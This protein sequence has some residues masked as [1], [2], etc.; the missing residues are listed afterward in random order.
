MAKN[1]EGSVSFSTNA[2]L[3]VAL[4][5]TLPNQTCNLRVTKWRL[6]IHLSISFKRIHKWLITALMAT[7]DKGYFVNKP[8][9][10]SEN[11]TSS[12]SIQFP[13][14]SRAIL[15]QEMVKLNWYFLLM[16]FI[17]KRGNGLCEYSVIL[18][19]VASKHEG[20]HIQV[21]KNSYKLCIL[22]INLQFGNSVILKEL[23]KVMS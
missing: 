8:N 11:V 15:R 18:T 21:S 12:S 14:A 9:V 4:C 5:L 1:P 20:F 19:T 2:I 7:Y 3:H 10:F 23:S 17:W 16:Y 13:V 6:N 22:T